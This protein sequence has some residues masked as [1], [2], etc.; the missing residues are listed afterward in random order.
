[1]PAI[2]GGRLPPFSTMTLKQ[3]QER[4]RRHSSE[5]DAI[6]LAGFFKTGP[7]EYGE[8]DRFLGIRVPAV[9]SVV[10]EVWRETP[11][12]SVTGLLA[13]PWH[14][15]RLCGLLIWVQ[16]FKK[17]DE[18]CRQRIYEDYIA[19]THRVNNWDLVD[20]SAEHVVGGRL[21]D[22]SRRPLD[23]LAKSDLL[24]DRRI[25]I[26]ATFHFIRRGD[27]SSTLR[28]AEMLK[29]DSEDL[30]HKAV[31]WMLREVGNRD[32]AAEE[33]FLR[34][35]YRELPRTLLRYAIE[36]FPEELRLAYLKGRVK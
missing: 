29:H 32:R 5:S 16:Q 31:G 11:H 26:L 28:L 17:G 27:F 25:S 1:M 2:D 30:M 35:T 13:S 36:R 33:A 6:Q 21:W 3:I 8:G 19:R 15:D 34:G 9:R 4:L 14:E 10:R 18:L 20:L 24:W 22:R 7:G 23:E 12:R